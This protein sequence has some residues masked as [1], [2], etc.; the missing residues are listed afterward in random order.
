MGATILM[1]DDR[2]NFLDESLSEFIVIGHGV[3]QCYL[4]VLSLT[5]GFSRIKRNMKK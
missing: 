5:C 4:I 3:T 2:G 1:R